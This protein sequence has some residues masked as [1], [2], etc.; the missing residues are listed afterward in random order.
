[1]IWKVF[2]FLSYIFLFGFP[3][4]LIFNNEEKS[5]AGALARLALRISRAGA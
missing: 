4:L 5:Y 2:I 3:A 1:M